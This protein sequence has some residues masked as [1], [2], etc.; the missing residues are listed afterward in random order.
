MLWEL[1]GGINHLRAKH[2]LEDEKQ[3]YTFLLAENEASKCSETGL[4]HLES[5]IELCKLGECYFRLAIVLDQNRMKELQILYDEKYLNK[6]IEIS[7]EEEITDLQINRIKY[8]ANDYSY[9][10]W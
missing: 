7:L 5:D 3:L 9:S 8:T 1:I 2:S 4:K 6:K 10:F